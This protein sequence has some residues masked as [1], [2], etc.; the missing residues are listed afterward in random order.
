MSYQV[1]VA[2]LKQIGLFIDTLRENNCYNNTRIVITSDHGW[3]NNIKPGSDKEK[4]FYNKKMLYF[5]PLL[6][7][8]DFNSDTEIKVDNKFMTNADTIF[9]AS[10][11]LIPELE[12]P[13]LNKDLKQ[14]KKNGVNVFWSY[15]KADDNSL[16]PIEKKYTLPIKD[17]YR[18]KN[19]F[20]DVQGWEEIK[21]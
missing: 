11:G 2:A 5:N 6:M 17:G 1:F 9:L 14:D 4:I 21:Y 13:F 3:K 16:I 8:K 15:N 18:I 12:N 20:F 10:D 19:G 7:V